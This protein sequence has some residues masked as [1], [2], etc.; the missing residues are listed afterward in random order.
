VASAPRLETRD[1]WFDY[2][3]GVSVL[4]GVSLDIEPGEFVAIIGQNGSGKTT[5]VKHFNGLLRPHRGQVLLDGED[6]IHHSVG[7]LARLVGYV[8]QN[9]DHQIFGATTHEE[10]A[11]GPVNF[12]LPEDEVEARTAEALQSFHL[13]EYA[14][15]QPAMLG[16][17][18]RRKV[19]IAAVYAMQTPILILDEPTTG[20]DW[21][22]TSELMQL[23]GGLNEQGRTIILITHDMRVIAEYVPRCMVIRKGEILIHDSTREVFRQAELLESTRIEVPQIAQL[24]R[25]MVPHGLQDGILTVPEFCDAYNDLMSGT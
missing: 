24:G 6:I 21:K 11:F 22:S 10:I 9:P 3:A 20:L 17:G 15:M 16:F 13:T 4:H 7:A 8:F 18:L 25:R 14:D 1:L 5:L 23:I 19:S 12:E 2:E